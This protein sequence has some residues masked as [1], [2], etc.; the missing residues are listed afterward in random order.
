LKLQTVGLEM[1][2]KDWS[3]WFCDNDRDK[4]NWSQMT[5]DGN[6]PSLKGLIGTITEPVR[7]TKK[8]AEIWI[9]KSTRSHRW[10]V[11][12]IDPN[13][14]SKCIEEEKDWS[15]WYV[16]H[17]D[18][19]WSVGGYK[20]DDQSLTSQKASLTQPIR[21]TKEDAEIWASRKS[22]I[23]C[24]WIAR[25]IDPNDNSK[26]IN[27]TNG[28]ETMRADDECWGVWVSGFPGHWTIEPYRGK[29]EEFSKRIGTTSKPL[30]TTKEDAEFW[31]INKGVSYSARRVDHNNPKTFLQ[32]VPIETEERYWSV[33]YSGSPG[34]WTSERYE[35]DLPDLEGKSRKGGNTILTT[36]ADAEIWAKR[37]GVWYSAKRFDPSNPSKFIDL[38]EEQMT[39]VKHYSVWNSLQKKWSANTT[40][41]GTNQ[42]YRGQQTSLHP[43]HL[44]LDEATA[45]LRDFNNKFPTDKYYEA[46]Q[47]DPNQSSNGFPVKF[48]SVWWNGGMK[49]SETTPPTGKTCQNPNMP[50]L[51]TREEADQWCMKS[52]RVNASDSYEVREIDHSDL[53]TAIKVEQTK[54][55]SVWIKS[56]DKWTNNTL[57]FKDA[58]GTLIEEPQDRERPFLMTENQVNEWMKTM[59]TLDYVVKEVPQA[60]QY[61][62]KIIPNEI[63]A[64]IPKEQ[65]TMQPKL[66]IHKPTKTTPTI[67]DFALGSKIVIWIDKSGQISD[68]PEGLPIDATII[69]RGKGVV[70]LGW[71]KNE[72]CPP[73]VSWRSPCKAYEYSTNHEKFIVAKSVRENTPCSLG[74]G[75]TMGTT[76]K[77]AAVGD[78]I[79]LCFDTEHKPTRFQT[80]HAVSAR[81]LS[82]NGDCVLI[83]RAKPTP[84]FV[85]C[86]PLACVK[87]GTP[88]HE[89]ICGYPYSLMC[90]QDVWCK[91]LGTYVLAN[92]S[93]RVEDKTTGK[94]SAKPK[95]EIEQEQSRETS[96]AEKQNDTVNEGSGIGGAIAAGIAVLAASA[97]S[98]ISQSKSNPVRVDANLASEV[99]NEVERSAECQS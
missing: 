98:T 37:K 47:I 44:S 89:D 16:C 61:P 92:D 10:S 96:V 93:R 87:D 24:I 35:G 82:V 66:E 71:K 72:P 55:Y 65:L 22:S 53:L 11:R 38:K 5:Y 28:L 91:I 74:F 60:N 94:M 3:I 51:L 57:K 39:D 12:K 7:T 21:T 76:L 63:S 78:P 69:G 42:K 84:G 70:L 19:G 73:M 15:V 99:F 86:D 23:G 20:G 79:D 75:E 97:I 50:F 27:E 77:Y 64:D 48:Y 83:G 43:H 13:D 14:S 30:L 33:W 18:G 32:D 29:R 34:Y 40:Y 80:N 85:E 4:G 8:D 46:R 81:V 52:R 54:Y 31:A 41:D 90:T 36:K 9:G 2:E 6:D 58:S 49:W 1:D 62:D 25:K 26:Y 88:F 68:K 45:W 17:K 56:L 67:K 95:D 59:S